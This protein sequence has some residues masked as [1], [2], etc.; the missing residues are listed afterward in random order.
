M[1]KGIVEILTPHEAK[2]VIEYNAI[3]P[4]LDKNMAFIGS[5]DIILYPIHFQ[6]LFAI[7]TLLIFLMSVLSQ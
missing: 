7:H 2:G 4:I 1:K 5:T 3:N 6:D